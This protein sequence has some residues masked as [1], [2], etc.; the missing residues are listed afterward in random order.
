LALVKIGAETL[1]LV[2]DGP[3]VEAPVGFEVV[4]QSWLLHSAD[5]DYLASVPGVEVAARPYPALAT[6]GQDDMG[7]QVLLDLEACGL[8]ALR[9]EDSTQAGAVLAALAVELSFSPWADELVLTL[10]G[11][12][13]GLP[14]AL[15]KH[16]VTETDAVD[17]L[18][19][20]LEQRA[21]VQRAYQPHEVLGR[22]RVD[23][24]L[25]EPWV[26]EIVLIDQPLTD[27]QSHRLTALA[28][29]EPRVPVAAV[30][31]DPKMSAPWVLEL[32]GS[33]QSPDVG[34]EQSPITALLQPLGLA[35][36]PQLLPT[37][38]SEAVF[39]LVSST[40]SD[41]TSP[42]PWWSDEPEATDVPS[43]NVTQLGRRSSGWGSL[44]ADNLKEIDEVAQELVGDQGPRIHHPILRL[45]GPVELVGANG[46][47]P[48][49]AGKQCLEYC[50]WLLQHPGTTAQAMASAL[51]VAEGTRRSNM[52]RLRSWLGADGEGQAY[53]PD[54]YTGRILLHPSVSSD[55]QR[56][57]I[58][59]GAGINKTSSPGL[60]AA[61][62]LVRGAPLAD[63]A[64]GQ[65]HWAEELRTDMISAVR[66]IGVELSSRALAD[67][68]LDLARWAAA[69]SLVAAPGDELLMTVRIRTEH[70]A[71]R[72]A[73][74]ERLTLQLAAQAR[75]LGMDLE[76]ET[77]T[78][79]QEVMEGRVRARIA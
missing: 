36:Q 7:N 69:R 13:T 11:S 15:G 4:G 19:T 64:P 49:R 47:V 34:R 53:L 54:A 29:G 41:Q 75:A 65:W 71:G 46:P 5:A 8:L 32:A 23:P 57:Q 73:E 18:L 17:V 20:R 31:A 10:V 16:N 9:S 77:V 63:A 35:V 55:W 66:D 6:L 68:Q 72:V 2:F 12:S 38:A 33:T 26:P 67:G 3:A 61:L 59:T 14:D 74:T 25:A 62:E 37:A 60:R 22:H 42:A 24:D 45:L 40:G 39:D 52:S 78:L 27:Q 48:P 30:I 56:L 28:T 44:A 70:L 79:L 50:G 76:P 1:E 58:L 51:V 43:D 21:E